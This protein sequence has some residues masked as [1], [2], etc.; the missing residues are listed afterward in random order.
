[1]DPKPLANETDLVDDLARAGDRQAD[2]AA[3]IDRIACKLI[4][5]ATGVEQVSTY[6]TR[7]PLPAQRLEAIEKLAAGHLDP[8][9]A[10]LRSVTLSPQL[11]GAIAIQLADFAE[12]ID[13][14]Q[15]RSR[16]LH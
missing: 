16:R 7:G 6:R 14:N 2:R 11:A 5:H 10:G 8:D 3:A 9:G 12:A 15:R 13:E 4:E 1:M